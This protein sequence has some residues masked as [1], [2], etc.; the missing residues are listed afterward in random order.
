MMLEGVVA[1]QRGGG[2]QRD[3]KLSLFSTIYTTYTFGMY[4][5]L[6][7][8]GGSVGMDL[9]LGAMGKICRTLPA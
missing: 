1:S 7:V 9:H 2:A 4:V 5:V 8:H 6:S 3:G